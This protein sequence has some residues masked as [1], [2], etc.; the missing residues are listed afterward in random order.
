MSHKMKL[1]VAVA[2]I[3]FLKYSNIIC[4]ALVEI[5][6]F[7]CIDRIYLKT[8][9]S[10]ILSCKLTSISD[11]VNI[12][13]GSA[14]TCKNKYFLDTALCDYPHL[15]FYLFH[16]KLHSVY[17]VITVESAVYAIIF[18]VICDIERCKYVN[19]I[20]EMLSCFVSC[21]LRHFFKKR[22]GSRGEQRF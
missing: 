2:V 13:F 7:F 21:L 4:A 14:F 22:F 8:N 11:I 12:A 16:I 10:E 17:T 18:T 6:I 9:I 5:L 20:S 19:G 15:M 3:C 1:F